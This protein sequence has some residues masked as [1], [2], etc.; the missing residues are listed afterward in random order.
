MIFK[1]VKNK[2]TSSTKGVRITNLASYIVNP[3]SENSQEKCIYSSSKNFL[4]DD[5]ELQIKEMLSLSEMAVRSKDTIKHYIFSWKEGEVPTS[6][7]VDEAVEILLAQM[8]VKDHQCLYGLHVDTDNYHVHMMLNRVHPETGKVVEINKGLDIEVGHQAVALIEHKQG[9]LSEEDSLYCIDQDGS[10]VRRDS[11]KD[12]KKS[13]RSSTADNEKRT[14]EKSAERMLIEMAADIIS[15]AKSWEEL[16]DKLSKKGIRYIKTGSGANVYIA[17]IA[18]KA[19][20]IHRTASLT[21]LEKRLGV[22]QP[23]RENDLNEHERISASSQQ[24]IGELQRAGRNGLRKLSV[25]TVGNAGS[26]WWR[27]KNGSASTPI[28]PSEAWLYRGELVNVRWQPVLSTAKGLGWDSYIV[29]RN[30]Y[31]KRRSSELAELNDKHIDQKRKLKERLLGY[32]KNALSGNWKGRGNELKALKSILAASEVEELENLKDKQRKEKSDFRKS[33]PLFPDFER[34]LEITKELGSAEKWRYLASQKS[35][36]GEVDDLGN[37]GDIR[38]YDSEVIGGDVHYVKVG[39][40]SLDL[41]TAFIDRGRVIDINDSGDDAILSAMQ[42]AA[43]KWGIIQ[44]NGS[45]EYKRKCAYIAAK[46]GFKISNPELQEIVAE[47]KV[48]FTE[49]RTRSYYPELVVIEAFCKAIGV[50]HCS[51]QAFSKKIGYQLLRSG[52]GVDFKADD[53]S[54]NIKDIKQFHARYGNAS[55]VPRS[56]DKQFVVL[57]G[58]NRGMLQKVID[59]GF[60]PCVVSSYQSDLYEVVLRVPKSSDVGVTEFEIL[61]AQLL[62]RYGLSNVSNKILL[63]GFSVRNIALL[64]SDLNYPDNRV[65]KAKDRDCPMTYSLLSN[66]VVGVSLGDAKGESGDYNECAYYA[67]FRDV[68]NL[69][70][71]KGESL[72]LSR[73]D[74]MVSVRLRVLGLS[75]E[76]LK[77]LLLKVV[78]NVRPESEHIVGVDRYVAGLT[79]YVFSEAGNMQIRTFSTN[80]ARWKGVV[81]SYTAERNTSSEM[82]LD[83][84]M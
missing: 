29:E 58:V 57:S 15:E 44:L 73:I 22:F 68:S 62:G 30:A 32:R 49:E 7:Q 53:L 10:L 75:K 17:D 4:F 12:G 78:N 65:I 39:Q 16:H 3:E 61:S 24:G 51:I 37:V 20:A 72:N 28:L 35:M 79:G 71:A 54:A 31:K 43:R 81:D 6:D 40:N 47:Y 67:H 1:F 19:S 27:G 2:N 77:A 84:G 69:L 70:L 5:T 83:N 38:G 34:W 23:A 66:S 33:F 8:N 74:K 25:C 55:L 46:N 11:R 52:T 56:E 59:D 60:K 63:P 82:D 36:S 48:E 76:D 42:L 18:V 9:W 13:V 41:E 50:E 21:K 64:D 45:E 26:G 14:G 80:K